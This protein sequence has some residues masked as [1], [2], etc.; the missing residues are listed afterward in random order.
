MTE[1]TLTD[2]YDIHRSQPDVSLERHVRKRRLELGVEVSSKCRIYLDLRFWI[3]LREAYIEKQINKSTEILLNRL[4]ALVESGRAICPISE[5]VFVELL[6][7][8]DPTSR[9]AT[10]KLIDTLS[11]GVTLI[12]HPDRVRQELCNALYERAG[13]ENLIPAEQL[14]WTKLSSILG[15]VHPSGTPFGAAEELVIQKAFYDHMWD[16]SL[17]EIVKSINPA[18]MPTKDWEATAK[19]LNEG[20]KQHEKEITNYRTAY[21]FEFEGCLSLFR[22]EMLVLF[23]EIEA[24]GFHSINKRYSHLSESARFAAFSRSV[25]TLHIGASCHAAIRWDKKR[26]LTGNDLFDFHHAEAALGYCDIFLTEGPLKTLLSQNHL[27]L[28]GNFPCKIVSSVTE[29]VEAIDAIDG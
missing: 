25:R 28:K 18:R 11:C 2:I 24:T 17:I 1:K 21:R 15:D 10:A 27:E 3:L 26:M 20:N 16:V 12:V 9:I 23:K 6:K 19:R 8:D 13:A 29:A 5:S 4:I 7:Q 14:V 22:R